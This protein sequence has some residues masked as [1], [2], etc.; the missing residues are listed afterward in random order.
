MKTLSKVLDHS[1]TLS[2]LFD[3]SA[4]STSESVNCDWL[5]THVY[6]LSITVN[7]LQK[8]IDH[9]KYLNGNQALLKCKGNMTV[10]LY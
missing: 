6:K 9:S 1:K 7:Q 8:K 10:E 4:V 5:I 3:Q 2:Q